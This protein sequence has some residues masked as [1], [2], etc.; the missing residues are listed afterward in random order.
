M[1]CGEAELFVELRELERSENYGGALS[2]LNAAM[3]DHARKDL[4]PV[5]LRNVARIARTLRSQ[6]LGLIC[7]ALPVAEKKDNP[8]DYSMR[9]DRRRGLV[10][11]VVSLT[12]M[13]TR[14]H[15]V[16]NTVQTLLKQDLKPHSINVYVSTEPYLIDKGVDLDSPTIRQLS[17]Y[18]LVNLYSVQNIG[19]Y[20]KIYPVIYQLRN[21]GAPEDTPIVTVDDDCLYPEDL[22]STFMSTMRGT[23]AIVAHRGRLIQIDDKRIAPYRDFGTPS[24]EPRLDSL[25]VGRNGVAYKLRHFPSVREAYVGPL[26]AP[27]ADDLWIK[28]VTSIHCVPT[29]VLEPRAAY[30]KSLDFENSVATESNTLFDKFNKTGGN[31]TTIQALEAFSGSF[32][33][34]TLYDILSGCRDVR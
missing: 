32:Y 27:T 18:P 25:A 30:D 10:R 7:D 20:R 19:P 17:D 22:L 3:Y 8:R 11:P 16:L 24:P 12:T 23:A 6:V 28:W 13:S 33:G 5:Y 15:G 2:I 29:V 34:V 4:H 26:I 21:S 9:R 14:L 1:A 31:D